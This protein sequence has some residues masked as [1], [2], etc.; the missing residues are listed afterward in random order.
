M[1]LLAAGL[2]VLLLFAV[3]RS[4]QLLRTY[5]KWRA[6]QVIPGP[7]C[8]FLLGQF[9]AIRH[10]PFMAPHKVWWK[11]IVGYD[12]PLMRYNS[13]LGRNMLMVFDP[14]IIKEIL[15]APA[16][17][18]DC[19]FY[20]PIF[21]FPSI[22]GK[23]LVTLEGEEW[24]KHRRLIQPAFSVPFLKEA[25]DASVA[26][27]VE[28]F[29]QLWLKAGPKQEIDVV[30]HLS[31]LTLDVIGDIGFSHDCQGLKD[32]ERWAQAASASDDE[33]KSPELSDPLIT[34]MTA[35]LKPDMFRLFMYMS[36]FGMLDPLINPKTRRV[37]AALN[38][39]VDDIIANA[40]RLDHEKTGSSGNNR[41]RSLIQVLMNAKD[42]ESSPSKSKLGQTGLSDGE[43]RDELK[44]FLLAGHETTST[45]CYW[46]M[47]ALAKYPDVQ[48][49]LYQD[50]MKD[51]STSATATISLEQVERM[52]YLDVFLQECLRLF[53][54]VGMIMRLNRYEEIFAGYKIPSGTNLVVP[55]HLLHRHPKYWGPDPEAFQPERW[56]SEGGGGGG[57]DTKG[58]TFL[59]FGA[60]GHN[61]IGYRFATL[62]A[63]LIMAHMV[64][65]LR[66]EIAPSQRGVE[67]TF[68]ALI[69]MKAKPG[70]KVVV[71]QR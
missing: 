37:R 61:C 69:T 47:F 53:P 2:L 52:E 35:L 32:M 46:A 31:A 6:L 60:G 45:W 4:V 22:I 43:L 26:P 10:E 1:L 7:E 5:L 30:T 62:E 18:D 54:P 24:V 33:A 50:V 57:M 48:E 16:G 36:G 20:K 40:R 49:K 27:K 71:K 65:A 58:F 28:S 9:P 3:Y 34:S 64:R 25:L 15:T 51:S 12:A 63:K 41:T 29:I 14:A 59:P 66:I 44:T 19:R 23:G 8:S 17:K 11:D 13:I 55:V 56:L 38:D 21:F 70:L 67:H 39:S 42:T 68:T